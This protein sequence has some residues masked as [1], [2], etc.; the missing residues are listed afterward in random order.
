MPMTA[1]VFPVQ[2]KSFGHDAVCIKEPW[3]SCRPF[4]SG[5]FQLLHHQSQ[6]WSVPEPTRMDSTHFRIPHALTKK[7][8]ASSNC[9]PVFK[10]R[11]LTFHSPDGS[12]HLA[13]T[14]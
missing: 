12:S 10:S 9:S 13:A 1:T 8:A 3:K 2:S 5:H 14:I 4:T 7:F 11:T 6:Q